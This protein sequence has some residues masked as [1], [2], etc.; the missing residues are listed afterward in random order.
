MKEALEY[1]KKEAY[2]E[3]INVRTRGNVDK[4]RTWVMA[5]LRGKQ[6]K[7]E[8]LRKETKREF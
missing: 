2:L 1:Q 6:L 5:N 8:S 3:L 4:T 7:L